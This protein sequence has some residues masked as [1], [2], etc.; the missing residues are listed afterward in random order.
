[1]DNTRPFELTSNNKLIA[2]FTS[3][4]NEEKNEVYSF[5]NG[6]VVR[7]IIVGSQYPSSH[8]VLKIGGILIAYTST[9]IKHENGYE[10]VFFHDLKPLPLYLCLYN[11]LQVEIVNYTRHDKNIRLLLETSGP[12]KTIRKTHTIPLNNSDTAIEILV[13]PYGFQNV[14]EDTSLRFQSGMVGYNH[15]LDHKHVFFSGLLGFKP[16][17]YFCGSFQ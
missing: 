5:V 6:D 3:G 12:K 17:C 4:Y 14:P 11:E 16:K 15:A 10:A 2:T 8:A 1:M 13:K 9:Y 7:F